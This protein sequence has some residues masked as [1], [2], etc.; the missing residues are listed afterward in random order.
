MTAPSC[1]VPASAFLILNLPWGLVSFPH[2][3]PPPF[4]PSL[5]LF[6]CPFETLPHYVAQ[7]G[8]EFPGL[9]DPPLKFIDTHFRACVSCL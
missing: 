3:F 4:L 1:C 2:V 5:S 7:A 6:L 8:L 9:G